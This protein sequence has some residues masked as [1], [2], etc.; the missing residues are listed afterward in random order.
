MTSRT[1]IHASTLAPVDELKYP[2]VVEHGASLFEV[3]HGSP[4]DQC[5][6]KTA[7]LVALC[8]DN[9][10]MMPVLMATAA[11]LPP[12][13]NDHDRALGSVNDGAEA[14]S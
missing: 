6:L 4:P 13:G 3:I 14:C 5:L 9:G 11:F 1:D 12:I 2:E 10:G 7:L 8:V